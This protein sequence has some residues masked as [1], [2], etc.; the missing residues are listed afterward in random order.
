MFCLN[1]ENR[2]QA[3]SENGF[4][5]LWLCS[6]HVGLC[7]LCDFDHVMGKSCNRWCKQPSRP[8]IN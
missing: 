5:C 2:Q 8:D 7:G 3:L 4:L 1:K 6:V